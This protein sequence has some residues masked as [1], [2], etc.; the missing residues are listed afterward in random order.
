MMTLTQSKR[1][2]TT[3]LMAAID[4]GMSREQ[5]A[6]AAAKASF[7]VCRQRCEANQDLVNLEAIRLGAGSLYAGTG[8]RYCALK[9][10]THPLMVRAQALLDAEIAAKDGMY[11]AAYALFDWAS[12]TALLRHASETQKALIC[13]MVVRVKEMA[14]V[15]GPF[16]E[17]VGLCMRVRM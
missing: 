10:E 12:E 14:F 7:L 2:L 4:S 16:E 9:D 1:M 5:L 17:L 6:Y 8:P 3:T 13:D 11:L 15:E